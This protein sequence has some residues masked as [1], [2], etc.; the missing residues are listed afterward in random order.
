MYIHIYLEFEFN[1]NLYGLE[2]NIFLSIKAT[3]GNEYF[4]KA[5]LSLPIIKY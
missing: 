4:C 3:C 2:G 1:A 5:Q